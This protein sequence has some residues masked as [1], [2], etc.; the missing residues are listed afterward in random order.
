MCG[1]R[2]QYWL[3]RLPDGYLFI[4]FSYLWQILKICVSLLFIREEFNNVEFQSTS[5]TALWCYE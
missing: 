1:D 2:C 4:I 3:F 5:K